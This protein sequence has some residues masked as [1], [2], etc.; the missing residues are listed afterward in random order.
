[1]SC[2]GLLVHAV[3][4][5]LPVLPYVCPHTSV[6]PLPHGPW[7]AGHCPGMDPWHPAGPPLPHP[8]GMQSFVLFSDFIWNSPVVFC[9]NNQ[10]RVTDTTHFWM[11]LS[12]LTAKVLQFAAAFQENWLRTENHLYLAV[13]WDCKAK[14]TTTMG[15]L[16]SGTDLAKIKL[17]LKEP[18]FS[19]KL[20][21]LCWSILCDATQ[22]HHLPAASASPRAHLLPV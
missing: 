1:M 15:V 17:Q 21:F 8:Q 22:V 18:P 4:R 16:T 9:R 20:N 10:W 12:E 13:D 2:L 6:V 19:R 5:T 14:D 3:R 11:F 7:G